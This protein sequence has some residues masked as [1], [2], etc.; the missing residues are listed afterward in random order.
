MVRLIEKYMNKLGKIIDIK[1]R[2][3]LYHLDQNARMSATQIAKKAGLSKDSVNYRIKRLI[4]RGIIFKFM[5]LLDTAKLGLTTFKV[6]YRFQNTT[7][8]KEQEIIDY[9]TSSPH[10]QLVTVAE[11]MFD[12]NLNIVAPNAEELYSIL[13]TIHSAYGNYLAER[14]VTILAKSHFFSREYLLHKKNSEIKRP[15]FFGSKPAAADIDSANKKILSLLAVDARIS[16]IQISKKTGLSNVSTISRMRKLEQAGIIQNYVI[17]LNHEKAG[18]SWY[19]LLLKLKGLTP[20]DDKHFFHFCTSHPNI[21]F[22]TTMIGKWDC[23]IGI[24]VEQDGEFKEI[25]T[26]IKRDFSS[27]LKEYTI[28]KLGE[29]HKFN[30][31]PMGKEIA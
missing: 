26:T 5:T 12:L 4:E 18:Y 9:L 6:F 11:G 21:W 2:K 29:T 19:Y 25:L 14:E 27:I 28:L 10:T 13:G 30:Q 22:H 17:F 8:K 16:A 3:I 1:D 7:L 31:Y 23:L 24:D 15:M 20:G